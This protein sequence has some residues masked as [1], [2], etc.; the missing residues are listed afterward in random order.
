MNVAD[1]FTWSMTTGGYSLWDEERGHGS[2]AS[3]SPPPRRLKE[4]VFDRCSHA[5]ID[6]KVEESHPRTRISSGIDVS[7]VAPYT[8]TREGDRDAACNAQD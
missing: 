4:T 1:C 7:A 2:R 3:R 6:E 8:G 5:P